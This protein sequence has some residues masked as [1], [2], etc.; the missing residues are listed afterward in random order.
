[1]WGDAIVESF[2]YLDIETVHR[3]WWDRLIMRSEGDS[4]PD[5]ILKLE[6]L[7]RLIDDGAQCQFIVDDRPKVIRAWES[8]GLKVDDVGP[9]YEF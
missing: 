4:R 2:D 8:R 6:F 7:D 5:D 9:G 1:M 3:R